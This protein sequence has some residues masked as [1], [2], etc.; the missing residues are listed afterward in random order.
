[1]APSSTAPVR[2]AEAP[3]HLLLVED[4][5]GDA[6]L[7]E[8]LLEDG[9]PEHRRAPRRA[10]LAAAVES[11]ATEVPDCVLLDLGL[12]DATGLGA[13]HRLRAA[14]P[15][16]ADARPHR[17][18]P[19]SSAA[20]RRSAA[21]AQDY[22]VKGQRR[23]RAAGAARSATRS[24]AGGPTTSGAQLEA[25]RAARRGERA[26]GARPAAR[27][28][29]CD[30]P[31]LGVAP[32][33][34]PGRRARAARRRLLRRGR[35]A[36]TA[37]VHARD[38]RRLRA[39]GPT[40][41][42]SASACG[43][44][45]ARCA[46]RRPRPTAV[47]PTL[48]LVHVHERHSDVDLHDAPDGHVAPDR[49]A[50]DPA[51]AGP[52]AAGAD[53]RR[54]AAR[55]RAVRVGARRWAS[56]DDARWPATVAVAARPPWALLLYTDGLIEGR[57]GP[58]GPGASAMRGADRRWCAAGRRRALAERPRRFV[59]GLIDEVERR[60]GGVA[61][62]RRRRA[63]LARPADRRADGRRPLRSGRQWFALGRRRPVVAALVG[64]R[65]R[66]CSR[67]SA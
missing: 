4:D 50:A 1:M 37:R 49:R 5:D 18:S 32:R 23:R 64:D 6:F 44:P 59:G 17:R 42:R 65:R 60:N 57:A 28:R 22:L 34:R 24:S 14:A 31:A 7:V 19:T 26:P 45:G 15:D 54:R 61:A 33:Y 53:R 29:W 27:R 10:S 43:S 21:G 2:A 62:R 52:S 48:Q 13:L 47:L 66:R 38:R 36:P 30:D 41:R 56:L 40:R 8:E 63:L 3:L 46:R 12:P 67:C 58:A 35:D 20:S 16:V 51:L 11:L 55:A 9:G 25:R 39:T